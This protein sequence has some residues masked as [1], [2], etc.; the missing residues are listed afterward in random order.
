M[1]RLERGEDEKIDKINDLVADVIYNNSES[2]MC[3]LLEMFHPMILGVCKRWSTYFRDES[4]TIKPFDDLVSDAQLWFIKYTQ[5][6]YTIDG[7]AT[8]N[9]FI[10]DHISQRVRY[11][12]ECELKYY[13]RHI[14]P[15]PDKNAENDCDTFDTVIHKYSSNVSC[16]DVEGTIMNK[17][18]VD[19]RNELAHTILSL[20]EDTSIFNPREKMIFTEIVYNGRTHEELGRELCIS[21]TRVTHILKKIK[22]K[23]YK[24]MDDCQHLWDL[25]ECTDIDFR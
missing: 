8:Y 19:S 22:V 20:L 2:S 6:V 17:I 1:A 18:D 13:K 5:S 4:H 14:F 12:Y 21:R 10:K 9:K 7:A 24:Q 15:D 23:L 25:I 16:N 3:S 11:I